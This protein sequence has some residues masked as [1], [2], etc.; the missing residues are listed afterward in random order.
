MTNDE[1]NDLRTSDQKAR[2]IAQ[3]RALR[4]Q[5]SKGGLRFE[6]YLPSRLA[7]WMLDFVE[8][9]VFTDPGEAVFVMLGEQKD[10]E[11]HVDLRDEILRRTLEAASKEPTI[12]AEEFKAQMD[13][14]RAEPRSQPAVWRQQKYG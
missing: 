9:G 10:L 2:D 7:Q 8:R 5:A 3:A 13:G 1:Y 4:D 14:R 12:S 11:P 6:V